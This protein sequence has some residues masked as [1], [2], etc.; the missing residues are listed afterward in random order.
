MHKKTLTKEQALQKLKHFC[1]YQERCNCDVRDKLFEL[2]VPK[3]Y[4][5][6]MIQTLTE[7]DI[8]NEERFASSF[9]TGKFR[10]NH[11]GKIKIRYEL[12]QK[13][14]DEEYIKNALKQINDK[15]YEAILKE[16]ANEKYEALKMEQYLVRKKKTI[17]Y[18]LQKGYEAELINKV[19]TVLKENNHSA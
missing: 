4:H 13:K 2:R 11:W 16:M 3:N 9:A 18:L 8:L 7:T 1:S 6:D 10:I 17:N 5:D 15:E 12:K 19:L 14:I